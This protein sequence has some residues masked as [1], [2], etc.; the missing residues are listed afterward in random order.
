MIENRVNLQSSPIG[1]RSA[2]NNAMHSDGNSAAD[3]HGLAGCWLGSRQVCVIRP[4]SVEITLHNGPILNF[5]RAKRLLLPRGYGEG[6]I[7]AGLVK[8]IAPMGKLVT[9]R[10]LLRSKG[11]I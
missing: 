4:F 5:L 10:L 11:T 3:G 2:H 1:C 6:R 7:S 8:G 9:M